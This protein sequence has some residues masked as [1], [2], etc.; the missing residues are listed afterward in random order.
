M[1]EN[2]KLYD[3]IQKQILKRKPVIALIISISFEEFFDISIQDIANNYLLENNE[4]NH[5]ILLGEDSE[6][7]LLDRQVRFDSLFKINFP[8]GR[9][10]YINIE[11]Q[12]IVKKIENLIGRSFTYDGVLVATQIGIEIVDQHYENLKKTASI[13]LISDAPAKYEGNAILC[14]IDQKNLIGEAKFNHELIDFL[15]NVYIF[16]TKDGKIKSEKLKVLSALLNP[17]MVIK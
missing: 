9:I 8:D 16:L 14:F 17:Y 6:I 12:I 2:F 15:N 11:I 10:G 3:R 7:N 5:S 1:D 13:W 4:S